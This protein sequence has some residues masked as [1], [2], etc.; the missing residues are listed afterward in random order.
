MIIFKDEPIACFLKKVI[1]AVH[2][3]FDLGPVTCYIINAFEFA[4]AVK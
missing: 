2:F 1:E 4:L 3:S